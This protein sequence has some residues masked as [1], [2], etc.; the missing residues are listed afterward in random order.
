[1]IEFTDDNGHELEGHVVNMA[2]HH[3]KNDQKLAV[4]IARYAL[5]TLKN[6]IFVCQTHLIESCLN[7]GPEHEENFPMWDEVQNLY[8]QNDW[9]EEDILEYIEDNGGVLPEKDEDGDYDEDEL[10]EAARD[11]PQRPEVFEWWAVSRHLFQKL[12]GQCQPVLEYAGNYWWGRCTTGQSI[13][14]DSILFRIGASIYS[15]D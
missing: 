6:D 9:S 4:D 14:L 13:I 10:V 7:L 12:D 11:S 15:K 8:P 3:A 2:L 1:M 5:R